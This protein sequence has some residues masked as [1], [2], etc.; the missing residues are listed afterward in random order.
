MNNAV[1]TRNSALGKDTAFGA[2][3]WAF[4]KEPAKRVADVQL[5]P[6]RKNCPSKLSRRAPGMWICRSGC[7]AE[8]QMPMANR[9]AFG[10]S[11]ASADYPVAK[12]FTVTA[13]LTSVTHPGLADSV[14]IEVGK[15]LLER[16]SAAGE[17]VWG[18]HYCSF[19]EDTCI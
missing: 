3:R 10:D 6:A 4:G 16:G 13:P 14:L 8:C 12:A 7:A 2:R 15:A 5:R 19:R 1:G 18:R 17:R 9:P 11:S